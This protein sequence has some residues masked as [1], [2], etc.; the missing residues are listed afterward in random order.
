MCPLLFKITQSKSINC[1]IIQAQGQNSDQEINAKAMA[2]LL[3]IRKI[4]RDQ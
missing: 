3:A 1:F 2:K 4:I